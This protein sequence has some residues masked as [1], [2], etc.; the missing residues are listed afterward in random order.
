VKLFTNPFVF[1]REPSIM[2]DKT[3][4]E[5]ECRALT[6]GKSGILIDDPGVKNVE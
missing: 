6:S 5:R 4:E 2:Y 3:R 1:I